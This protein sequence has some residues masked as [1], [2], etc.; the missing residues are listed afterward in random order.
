M[1]N[2]PVD[3]ESP[4]SA[5]PGIIETH[6]GEATS[7]QFGIIVVL[8]LGLLTAPLWGGSYL[9]VL[10]LGSI[11]A[12]LVMGWDII[13]GHTGYISFGHSALSGSA[14]YST[15]LLVNHVGAYPMYVTIPLAIF[16]AFVVGMLF[17]LPSLRL[18]GPYFSLV[19][20]LSAL[21]LYRLV[22]P[23]GE[24]TGGELG[25]S[26]P[27]LSSDPLIRYYTVLVPMLVIAGSLLYISR[28]NVGMVFKAIRANEPA[29]ESAGLDTTKFKLW[30]FTLSSIPMGIGGALLG[31]FFGNADPGTLLL[32]DRSIEMIVISAIGGMGSI[33]GPLFAAYLFVILRDEVL[34]YVIGLS[35]T[36]RWIVLWVF[37]AAML[38]YAREGIFR[39][40]YLWIGQFSTLGAVPKGVVDWFRN[41]PT[42]VRSRFGGDRQ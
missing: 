19:T 31:H 15:A 20:F 25:V 14:A 12:I 6:F 9:Y 26:M 29:V 22:F 4:T 5:A 36:G 39:R 7:I 28:S 13:S 27:R 42:R 16:V 35:S 37:S 23:F 18:R 38:I 10:T 2:E 41:V 1:S 30:A 3:T 24:Y 11:W 33:L 17:A 8:V 34:L 40:F 32:I 21:I